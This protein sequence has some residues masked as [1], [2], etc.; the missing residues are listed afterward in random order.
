MLTHKC[1]RGFLGTSTQ[2]EFLSKAV[3]WLVCRN[4]KILFNRTCRCN[5]LKATLL[6]VKR[7]DI[8]DDKSSPTYCFLD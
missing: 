6:F 2:D 3:C 4:D 7:S 5:L 1:P 8:G